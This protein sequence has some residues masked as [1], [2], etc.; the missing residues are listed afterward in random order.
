MTFFSAK[1][2]PDEPDSKQIKIEKPDLEAE[3]KAKEALKKQMT[4]IFYY[5]DLLERNLKKGE[6]QDLLEYNKQEVPTGNESVTGP[7]FL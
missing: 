4:K 1:A 2:D 5:R 6:L 3:K 7:H